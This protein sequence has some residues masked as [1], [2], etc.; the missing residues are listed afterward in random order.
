[1]TEV[2]V[3]PPAY[4]TVDYEINP[5][6]HV[7]NKPDRELADSQ[8]EA[9]Y[10]LLGSLGI[11]VH[12]IKPEEGLPDMVFTANAG[13]VSGNSFIVSN[14]RYPQR[15]KEAA[16]FASWFKKRGYEI[17]SLPEKHYFEGEGDA[18]TFADIIIAGF[19]FRSDINSH[20][21][22][23]EIIGKRVI[24]LELIDP[25][26]YHL[27]TCFFTLNDE[28]ALY[29]PEAFDSYGKKVLNH[30]I[31]HLIG[32]GKKDAVNFC[33]NALVSGGNVIMNRCTN[34]LKDQ[35]EDLGFNV[36]QLNFSEFIK[37]G[38][39]AKCLA[40]YLRK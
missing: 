38:G 24:S 32:M 9:Y 8:W 3:C 23:G 17:I 10:G 2:L 16:I 22:I 1:M 31:P 40:L 35:L 12:K 20:R 4:Y 14:F 25:D 27:D 15:Q 19:R 29:Y 21:Y 18:L 11:T 7:R 36:H 28:T 30:H 34:R 6:M 39:S 33:C 5:W 26:F 37:A 13:L